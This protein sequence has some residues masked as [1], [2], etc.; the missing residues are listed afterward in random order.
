MEVPLN[1]HTTRKPSV[2]MIQ[3]L[4]L[5]LGTDMKLEGMVALQAQLARTEYYK[6]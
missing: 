4:S 2:Q 6:L 5:N 1:D 3:G